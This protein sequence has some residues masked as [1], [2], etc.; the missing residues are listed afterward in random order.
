[1]TSKRFEHVVTASPSRSTLTSRVRHCR[2]GETGW[3]TN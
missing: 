3:Y 2:T 1:M